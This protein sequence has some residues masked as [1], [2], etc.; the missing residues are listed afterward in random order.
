MNI[1]L[2]AAT[3]VDSK[4]KYHLKKR[5]VLLNKGI[6]KAI[7]TSLSIPEKSNVISLENLHISTGW[8]DTSV[9][10]GEPGYEERETIDNG[11]NTAAKSGFTHVCVNAANNPVTDHKSAVSFLQNKDSGHLTQLYVIGALTAKSEGID[12]SEMYDMF[13]QGA[14]SFYDYKKPIQNANLLKIALQYAQNFDG[15]VQSFPQDRAISRNGMANE[16]INSTRLGIKGMPTLAETLQ[17]SRDLYLLAYTGGKLHIPTI[18]T[19]ESVALIK[20]AKKKG[21]DI[22]CSVATY[23][24]ALTDDKLESFDTHYKL[25]PPLRTKDDVKALIKGLKE[26]VIDGVTS[27]HDPKDIELKRVE[28]DQASFGGI[29]LESCFGTLLQNLDIE[30][31]IASL[32]QL[33]Q[34][35]GIAQESITEEASTSLTLFNPEVNWTFTENDIYSTSKNAPLLGQKMKGKVYGIYSKGKLQIN[36]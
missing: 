25:N 14:V 20:D 18:S 9:N 1:L 12:L 3:I 33:K 2:K 32:T 24:L 31:A 26:G 4:S 13:Q 16:H 28:F 21:L 30:T 27:D 17:I 22:T 10:F 11:L 35:F 36:D 8:L 23:N 15:L 7:G 34:R 29:G 6:I 5:D 19:K